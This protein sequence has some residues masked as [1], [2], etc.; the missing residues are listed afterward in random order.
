MKGLALAGLLTGLTEAFV[1]NPFE[2]V[3]VRLQTDQQKFSSVNTLISLLTFRFLESIFDFL[4]NSKKAHL[5]RP[6]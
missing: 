1:A 3:K 5:T 2:V 4:L 6:S